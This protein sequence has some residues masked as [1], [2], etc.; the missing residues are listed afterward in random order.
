MV[1]HYSLSSI[2]DSV[3]WSFATFLVFVEK[4]LRSFE[5]F[6]PSY[7]LK[8][9]LSANLLCVKGIVHPVIYSV[10]NYSCRSKPVRFL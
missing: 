5:K 4:K 2:D 3:I 10:I 8:N 6:I 9:L 7:K 1:V